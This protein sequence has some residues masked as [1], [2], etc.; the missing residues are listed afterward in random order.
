[1]EVS[2]SKG[3][4]V[5]LWVKTQKNCFHRQQVE[6]DRITADDSTNIRY[7]FSNLPSRNLDFN[8]AYFKA[9]P[10]SINDNELKY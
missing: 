6:L 1:M 5:L 3:Q 10:N 4:S 8:L 7:S 9:I 2:R